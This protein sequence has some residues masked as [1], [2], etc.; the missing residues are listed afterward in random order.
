M[1]K[2]RN[3][4]YRTRNIR[5]NSWT[6]INRSLCWCQDP[7]SFIVHGWSS[8]VGWEVLRQSFML[9]EWWRNDKQA[10][11]ASAPKLH[12]SHCPAPVICVRYQKKHEIFFGGFF[13]EEGWG[14][15][16]DTLPHRARERQERHVAPWAHFLTPLSI[17]PPA[18]LYSSISFFH[19]TR[20]FPMVWLPLWLHT[21]GVCFETMV[22]I[23]TRPRG[24]DNERWAACAAMSPMRPGFLSGSH[25]TPN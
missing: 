16:S 23:F 24:V 22:L 21:R 1:N 3:L 6:N 19:C 14:L 11:L 7:Y 13:V 17:H 2:L 8:R 25:P 9:Y 15:K 18:S 10:A 12:V 4:S 5:I 20:A